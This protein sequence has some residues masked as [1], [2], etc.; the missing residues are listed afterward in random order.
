MQTGNKTITVPVPTEIKATINYTFV[1][2]IKRFIKKCRTNS[3]D[4][5]LCVLYV[6][7]CRAGLMGC[8]AKNP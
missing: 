2:T 7:V 3:F 5:S 4:F 1:G 8:T 6:C